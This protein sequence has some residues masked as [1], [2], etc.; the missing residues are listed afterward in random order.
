LYDEVLAATTVAKDREKGT[1][2]F[3]SM[4]TSMRMSIPVPSRSVERVVDCY[5]WHRI[6][7]YVFIRAKKSYIQ[8]FL[9]GMH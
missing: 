6:A 4:T 7:T 1:N 9:L 3:I 8:K 5:Y 2:A